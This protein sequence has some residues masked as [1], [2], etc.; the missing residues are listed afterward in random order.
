[1]A[2]AD[3][4]HLSLSRNGIRLRNQRLHECASFLRPQLGAAGEGRH[5]FLDGA[6]YEGSWVAGERSVGVFVAGDASWEY[7]GQWRGLERHGQGTLFQKG[8]SKCTGGF[9]HTSRTCLEEHTC[10][11]CMAGI[12]HRRHWKAC[13]RLGTECT[14]PVHSEGMLHIEPLLWVQGSGR[15][16]CRRAWAPASTWTA[17]STGV[18]RIASG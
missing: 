8:L 1:M 4:A 12:E 6:Y 9:L 10:T 15:R 14:L 7:R 16:T 17:P 3:R 13:V 11:Q 18:T 2:G 5:T